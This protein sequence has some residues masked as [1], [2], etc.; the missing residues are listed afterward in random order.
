MYWSGLF[1]R[2]EN[3]KLTVAKVVFGSKPGEPEVYDFV[4]KSRRTKNGL[5]PVKKSV[6]KSNASSS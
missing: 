6:Q 2:V 4:L 5:K 1:E 3:N